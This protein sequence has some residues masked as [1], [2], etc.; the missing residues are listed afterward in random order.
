MLGTEASVLL[1]V[2]T[3]VAELMLAKLAQGISV[4]QALYEIRWNLA[5]KGNLLGLA[6]TLYGLAD[7]HLMREQGLV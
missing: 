1:A 4:G 6:Y 7:L 5:N 3:E 2:A